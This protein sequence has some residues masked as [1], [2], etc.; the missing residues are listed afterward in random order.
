MSESFESQIIDEVYRFFVKSRDFNGISLTSLCD[1]VGADR[2]TVVAQIAQ[3]VERGVLS[4]QGDENPHII[5]LQ[6]FSIE[7]QKELLSEA[8]KSTVK[9][10]DFLPNISF[11]TFQ[12][13]IYPSREYLT[14]NRDVSEFEKSPFTRE[15][16]LGEPQLAERYFEIRILEQYYSD[17]RLIFSFEDYSGKIAYY[18]ENMPNLTE[19]EQFYLKSFGLGHDDSRERVVVAYLRYLRDLT[20]DQQVHWQNYL[21]LNR[22]CRPVPE[23]TANSNGS[24]EMSISVF[25]AFIEEQRVLNEL[26]ELV[27]GVKLFK[28]TFE[29]SKRPREF[30]FFF[31]PTQKNFQNFVH[32]LDKMISENLEANFFKSQKIE[33]YTYRDLEG[34]MVERINKGTLQMLEEWLMLKYYRRD[35]KNDSARELLEPFRNVRK[36]RQRPAHAISNDVYNKQLLSEQKTIIEQAY[37]SMSNLRMIFQSHPKADSYELDNSTLEMTVRSF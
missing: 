10:L 28:Q 26:A 19:H 35:P 37:N 33:A 4:V 18:E 11:E 29:D 17:P 32:L 34:G 13:C 14:A 9:Q 22:E 27:F 23:Y 15:L 6:H 30:T 2:N 21:V 25:S 7:R 8:G 16:A 3:L 24:W 20:P 5:R 12:I 31:F 36:L 1:N